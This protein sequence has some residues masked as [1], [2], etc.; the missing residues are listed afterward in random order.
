MVLSS[1]DESIRED[2]KLLKD[3][4]FLGKDVEI[5]GYNLDIFTGLLTPVV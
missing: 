4:R 1:V 3:N 5:L 2:I